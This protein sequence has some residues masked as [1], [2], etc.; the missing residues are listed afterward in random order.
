M[1]KYYIITEEEYEK[2]QALKEAEAVVAIHDYIQESY[3]HYPSPEE[4]YAC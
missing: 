3:E 2:L 4:M 1:S